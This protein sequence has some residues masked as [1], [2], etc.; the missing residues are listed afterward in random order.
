[1]KF[2]AL[3]AIVASTVASAQQLT[4]YAFSL[5]SFR[6]ME[7]PVGNPSAVV[8]TLFGTGDVS[9]NFAQ[10]DFFGNIPTQE[11]TMSPGNCCLKDANVK[12]R[13]CGG[14][15]PEC[16]AYCQVVATN[17][18]VSDGRVNFIASFDSFQSTTTP[19]GSPA[20]VLK[21]VQVPSGA[22]FSSWNNF[23]Y[24]G[25]LSK[26]DGELQSGNCC[27]RGKDAQVAVCGKD[28]AC[29]ANCKVSSRGL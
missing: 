29:C 5:E 6:A 13:K 25:H 12:Q 4:P 1:M 3:I 2:T 7:R 27:I 28:D 26:S 23:D 11:N 10:F 20:A 19:A 21:P 14:K 24:Y 22:K 8:R 15:G 18:L 16:C 17:F 9:L